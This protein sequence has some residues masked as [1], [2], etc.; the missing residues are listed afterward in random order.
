MAIL[1]GWIFILLG[2]IFFLGGG[3]WS[4]VRALIAGRLGS[5]HLGVQIVFAELGFGLWLLGMILVSAGMIWAGKR[6]AR[7]G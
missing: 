5:A 4:V 6:Q 2:V 3:G 7:S 1:F